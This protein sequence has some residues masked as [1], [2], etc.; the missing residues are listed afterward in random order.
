MEG[1][2]PLLLAHAGQELSR[3]RVLQRERAVAVPAV[4]FQHARD[5]ELAQAA[6]RVVESQACSAEPLLE[7]LDACNGSRVHAVQDG[8]IERHE[9]T[10]QYERQHA[11]RT[12]LA[13]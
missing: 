2:H 3:A 1:P 12:R 7:V 9:V 4:E 6:V 5:D 8:E 13:A 10:E 11:F